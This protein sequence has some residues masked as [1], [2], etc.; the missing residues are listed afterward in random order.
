[1]LEQQ[2]RLVNQTRTRSSVVELISMIVGAAFFVLALFTV[3]NTI[4]MCISLGLTGVA[5]VTGV[6]ASRKASLARLLYSELEKITRYN[7]NYGL[8][9][10]FS[11]VKLYCVDDN[12]YISKILCSYPTERKMKLYLCKGTQEDTFVVEVWPE[13]KEEFKMFEVEHSIWDSDSLKKLNTFLICF[14]VK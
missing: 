9:I 7:W 5:T 11:P 2:K 14:A 4:L 6:L 8:Q 1:M 12:K 3:D 10:V 13:N